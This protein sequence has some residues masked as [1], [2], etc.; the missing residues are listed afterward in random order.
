MKK[1]FIFL[2]DGFET[3]EAM[4]PLDV[5]RRAGIPVQTVSLTSNH[6]VESVQG[7]KICADLIF[8]PTHFKEV[9][10]LILP[11]GMP[12]AENLYKF[13]PLT[14]LL[15][16]HA[17]RGGH[18]AAICASP[19][20]VLGQLGLLKGYKAT[21][22]PGFESMLA[23]AEY[24]DAPVVADRNMVLGNG[25]ANAQTWS[26][27]IVKATLG[28]RVADRIAGDMLYFHPCDDTNNFFG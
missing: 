10:W 25:P 8:D 26:L 5:L 22:Y 14:G 21:C 19:G 17:S 12:G 9:D 16:D 2:A 20:V 15:R 24:V 27:A 1:S 11:G 3:V 13:A 6:A 23:G 28:E 7:V 4:T 18:I